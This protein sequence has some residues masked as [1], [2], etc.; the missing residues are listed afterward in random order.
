M[1]M[2][3]ANIDANTADVDVAGDMTVNSLQDTVH[4]DNGVPLGA[5]VGVAVS[6]KRD[7]YR[8]R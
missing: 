1:T 6:T 3:G 5:S 4:T 7:A 8:G 2:S